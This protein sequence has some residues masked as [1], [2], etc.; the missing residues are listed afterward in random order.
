M[1]PHNINDYINFINKSQ[2][3]YNKKFEVFPF[4]EYG[5]EDFSILPLFSLTIFCSLSYNNIEKVKFLNE[6]LIYFLTDEEIKF[7]YNKGYIIF[8][9]YK[10]KGYITLENLDTI[11]NKNN[12][13]IIA[14]FIYDSDFSEKMEMY[15]NELNLQTKNTKG[16]QSIQNGLCMESNFSLNVL[17]N[18]EL[19]T[20]KISKC[21]IDTGATFTQM[22]F[23]ELWD[24]VSKEFKDDFLESLK[25][26]VIILPIESSTGI[27]VKNLIVFKKPIYLKIDGLIVPLFKLTVDDIYTNTKEKF[28]LV[29][30]DLISQCNTIIYRQE[31]KLKISM[32]FPEQDGLKTYSTL[33]LNK[34][35]CLIKEIQSKK[36]VYYHVGSSGFDYLKD[37]SFLTR[38][39]LFLLSLDVREIIKFDEDISQNKDILFQDEFVLVNQIFQNYP[40]FDGI[41]VRNIGKDFIVLKKSGKSI[42]KRNGNNGEYEYQNDIKKL[43]IGAGYIMLDLKN[44]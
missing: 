7:K 2:E 42:L 15:P 13:N 36:D 33:F 28:F 18:D 40:Q 19:K 8:T 16:I 31:E 41:Y 44:D 23:P 1:L 12:K 29:G 38:D 24:F 35:L 43:Q 27:G 9:D 5:I 25:K 17:K 26:E 30:M 20:I 22:N 14:H 21:I 3:L 6:F 4:Q 39:I 34:G 37:K 32:F 10:Y 11:R